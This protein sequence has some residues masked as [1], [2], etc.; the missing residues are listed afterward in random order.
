MGSSRALLMLGNFK[1]KPSFPFASSS[2][3]LKPF[4]PIINNN[5]RTRSFSTKTRSSLQPPDL[6]RLAETARISLA[7]NEVEEFAPKIRQVIDWF[8][9]LQAVDLGNVEPALRADTEGDNLR[10]DVPETF[11]NE[12]ALIASVPSYEEPYIKVPKVLNKE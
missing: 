7:P 2:S 3:S 6:P 9:Q 1:F 11:D 8:G 4:S 12:E 10:E 5:L